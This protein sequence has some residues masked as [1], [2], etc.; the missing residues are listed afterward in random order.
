MG[1]RNA[2]TDVPATASTSGSDPLTTLFRLAKEFLLA[3]EFLRDGIYS[4][5]PHPSVIPKGLLGRFYIHRDRRLTLA[6]QLTRFPV[7]H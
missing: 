7:A 4:V 2:S 3:N 1:F 6:L 5:E